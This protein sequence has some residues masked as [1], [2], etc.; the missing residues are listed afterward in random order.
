MKIPPYINEDKNENDLQRYLYECES[1]Q[2]IP[3]SK[4]NFRWHY[5]NS[6][7]DSVET[8]DFVPNSS[9]YDSILNRVNRRTIHG[10]IQGG[11]FHHITFNDGFEKFVKDHLP[12]LIDK[13][14]KFESGRVDYEFNS[15][16]VIRFDLD[17]REVLK[18]Q[19]GE[20]ISE[21]GADKIRSWFNSL[22]DK[23]QL[24]QTSLVCS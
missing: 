1:K 14:Y 17:C 6:C 11:R 13:G 5:T 8:H 9:F 20:N 24:K 12:Y 3:Y 19:I 23:Y 18:A 4:L 10:L 16:T 21:E 15:R 2:I 7:F 22:Y